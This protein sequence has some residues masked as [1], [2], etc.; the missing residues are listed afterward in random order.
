MRNFADRGAARRKVRLRDRRIAERVGGFEPACVVGENGDARNVQRFGYALGDA[1]EQGAGFEDGADFIAEAGKNLVGVVGVAEETLVDPCAQAVTKAAQPKNRGESEADDNHNFQLIVPLLQF[2]A[3]DEDDDPVEND[4]EDKRAA[5][6]KRVLHALANDHPDVHRALD[7]DDVRQRDGEDDQHQKRPD[8]EPFR[9]HRFE[10]AAASHVLNNDENEKRREAKGG[11]RVDQVETALHIGRTGRGGLDAS[12]HEE[13]AG[14]RDAEDEN[15]RTEFFQPHIEARDGGIIFDL[16]DIIDDR[17]SS[18]CQKADGHDANRNAKRLWGR[19]RKIFREVEA[20]EEHGERPAQIHKGAENDAEISKA[21]A[22][23]LHTRAVHGAEAEEHK[24]EKPRRFIVWPDGSDPEPQKDAKEWE[25]DFERDDGNQSAEQRR[26]LVAL[27]NE[28]GVAR[29]ARRSRRMEVH[30]HRIAGLRWRDGFT[31]NFQAR[32]GATVD[33]GD[34]VT[35]AKACVRRRAGNESG[36]RGAAV[37]GGGK[38]PLRRDVP[39]K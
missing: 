34:D 12:E 27:E 39:K 38:W 15:K 31:E 25:H 30:R 22:P 21:R 16:A 18:A 29:F 3:R 2:Q 37:V 11:A 9:E 23:R 32:E 35:V 13:T 6:R 28:S 26:R 8:H 17:E 14:S 7:D 5:A 36:G 19:V 1:F 4:L 10:I 20:E 33:G 24:D